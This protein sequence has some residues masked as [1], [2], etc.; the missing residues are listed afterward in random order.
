MRRTLPILLALASWGLAQASG[1]PAVK[2]TAHGA[3]APA[4]NSSTTQNGQEALSLNDNASDGVAAVVNDSIISDYDLRQ[5]VALFLATSGIHAS[6]A[7]LKNIRRQVLAQLE[8]ERLQILEAQKKNITVSSSEVD[9]AID[10][11]TRENHLTLDQVKQLLAKANVDMAT[12]RSQIAAQIAWTKTVQD[13]YGDRVSVSPDA[14]DA[15]LKRLTA[16]ANKPHF[17]VS[18]IFEAV[19]SPEQD[20]Q[21]FKNMQ[22]LLEQ[23]RAGAPFDAVAR[24]FSQ[25]PTAAAGGDIGIVQEG[26][27]VPELN[28][29]LEKMHAG[30]VTGPVKASGGYYLLALRARLEPAG[31]KVPSPAEQPQVEPG[32]LSLA[33]ILLPIGPKPAKPLLQNATQAAVVIREHIPGCERLPELVS[34][35]KG[36]MYF[37]LGKMQLATLSPDI[38]NALAKT[39]P[40]E[41]TM[42]FQSA[43]GIELIVRCDKPAPKIEVFQPPTRDQV[44]QQ[45]YEEQMTVY[46][47]RYLR[48][49]RRVA[50]IETAEDRG[51]KN[52]KSSSAAIR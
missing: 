41:T 6:E 20:P 49:L 46:A 23:I 44:E 25:N 48:D 33:R 19:D 14:V 51:F 39:Q 29:A 21:V 4:T 9:K 24:Q 37:N 18:E 28:A 26:Q 45:L 40:G 2:N 12:F 1:A 43:A 32:V 35:I 5:R 36:A 13:E 10:N 50:N 38:R 17:R 42:P 47:R 7:E 22:G 27:L 30:E 52:A 15:E 31:T 3:V 16:G 11:I 34:K 8:T